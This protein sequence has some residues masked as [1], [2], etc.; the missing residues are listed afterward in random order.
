MP[1]GSAS[2]H[3]GIMVGV[4]DIS[5]MLCHG[6]WPIKGR[7]PT[8]GALDVLVAV[9]THSPLPNFLPTATLVFDYCWSAFS[10]H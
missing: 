6:R 4:V 10:G 5:G 9:A 1:G 3:S 8:L 2:A 7:G